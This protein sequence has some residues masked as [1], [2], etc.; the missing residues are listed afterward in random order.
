MPCSRPAVLS[1]RSAAYKTIGLFVEIIIK[2]E[3]LTKFLLLSTLI[4]RRG[5]F[6]LSASCIDPGLYSLLQQERESPRSA[7]QNEANIEERTADPGFGFQ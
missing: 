7:Q 1:K 5:A 4:T 3:L 2:H 6:S